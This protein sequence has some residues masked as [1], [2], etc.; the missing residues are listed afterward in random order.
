MASGLGGCP[1]ALQKGGVLV[2]L[3]RWLVYFMENRNL[4]WMM[5]G[6]TSMS[7]NMN[8]ARSNETRV[9]SFETSNPFNPFN[10]L[11]HHD[12]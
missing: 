1:E 6:G 9:L 3:D 5:T 7:G 8:L 2:P 4:K 12:A 10:P 11:S